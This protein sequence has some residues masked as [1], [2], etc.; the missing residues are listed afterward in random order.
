[1]MSRLQDGVLKTR[2]RRLVGLRRSLAEG[3]KCE[4]PGE[5]IL[6]HLRRREVALALAAGG[7][8]FAAR[9]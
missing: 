8:A 1:M 2:L 4:K 3:A 7:S 9:F 6:G 5:V